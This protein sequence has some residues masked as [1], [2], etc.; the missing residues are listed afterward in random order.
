MSNRT[1]TKKDRFA[2][3][4]EDTAVAER[5]IQQ[6]ID[7]KE[8]ARPKVKG[9]KNRAMQAGARRYPEPPDTA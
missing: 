4:A 5:D 2:D 9:E 3:A 1:P 7:R 8:K 6:E